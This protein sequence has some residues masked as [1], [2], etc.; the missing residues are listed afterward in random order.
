MK[1]REENI[2]IFIRYLSVIGFLFTILILFY[3]AK[4]GYILSPE[5]LTQ[6]IK[7]A[8]VAAPL[9]FI[10]LQIIQVVFPIIPG[11]IGCAAGVLLFGPWYGFLYNYIG[12]CIGSIINFLLARR[13]GKFLVK[14]F[15][16]ERI[17]NK[18]I[19]W[20]YQEKSFV[21][22]FA[23]AIFLPVAPDDFLCM[24]AGLTNMKL[25]TFAKIIIVAKPVS[26]F[27]YSISL[28]FGLQYFAQYLKM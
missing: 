3:A 20:T 18:Y 25:K 22:L 4:E 10:S 26:I 16:K 17:Y 2:K 11:G 13:Y 7:T 19:E 21:K 27:T 28:T 8:G 1:I 9:L 24:V 12:I 14:A 23:V 15:V 5:K 6:T